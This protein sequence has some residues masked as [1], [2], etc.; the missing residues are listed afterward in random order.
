MLLRPVN[1]AVYPAEEVAK[2]LAAGHHFLTSIMSG[3]KLFVLGGP[4]DLAAAVKRKARSG[5]QDE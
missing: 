5:A 4:D 3:A 2:K 1:P